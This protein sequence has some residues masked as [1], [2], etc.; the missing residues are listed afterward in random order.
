M[1]EITVTFTENGEEVA[2]VDITDF[3]L[4]ERGVDL[5]KMS[6]EDKR[7]AGEKLREM[8]IT[9]SITLA[10]EILYSAPSFDEITYHQDMDIE[11]AYTEN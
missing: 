7:L 5:N 1:P 10:Q 3:A 8:T 2:T 9:E 6:D 4:E 11:V